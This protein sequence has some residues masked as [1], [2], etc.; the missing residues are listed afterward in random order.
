[1]RWDD[2][3][4]SANNAILRAWHFS[5]YYCPADGTANANTWSSYLA[6]TGEQTAWPHEKARR[7][8][9]FGDERANKIL[10]VEAVQSGIHWTEPR[11]LEFDQIDL[12]INGVSTPAI[13]SHHG[14]GANVSF[15][16][17]SVRFLSTAALPET[18]RTMLTIRGKE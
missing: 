2:P 17:G 9:D 10:F 1:L 11:D 7:L 4:D 15:V 8:E 18:L 5:L 3:W 14:G 6:V 12:T 13:S 16:D